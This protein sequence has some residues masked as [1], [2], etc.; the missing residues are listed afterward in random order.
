MHP[1]PTSSCRTRYSLAALA[2]AAMLAGH[3]GVVA[4]AE[5]QVKPG[6]SIQAALNRA[7]AGDTLRVAR[8]HYPGNLR[9]DKPLRLIGEGRPTIDGLGKGDTIR[10]AAE[11]VSVEGFI[12]ADSG[13]DLGEQHAGIYIQPGSHRARVARCDFT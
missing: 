10:V 11:D 8:G 4:S 7:T 5:W 12:I 1:A 2:L 6:E 3:T 9:I 13:A